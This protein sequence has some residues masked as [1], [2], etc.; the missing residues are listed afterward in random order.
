MLNFG[1]IFELLHSMALIHD[2]IIDQ[3]DKRH[4]ALTVHSYIQTLLKGRPNAHHIAE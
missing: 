4:N 3:A 1:I 2:D